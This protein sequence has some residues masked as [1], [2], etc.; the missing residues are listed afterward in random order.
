VHSPEGA[1]LPLFTAPKTSL[2]F[3]IKNP[4]YIKLTTYF[5]NIIE[6]DNQRTNWQAEN[7]IIF[8]ISIIYHILPLNLKWAMYGKATN[9]AKQ[10]GG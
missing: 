3:C 5:I 2:F 7:F 10:L 9:A 4:F 6:E 8:S 1:G